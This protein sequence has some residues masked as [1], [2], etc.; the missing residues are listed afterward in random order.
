MQVGVEDL[1]TLVPTKIIHEQMQ[2]A[3][4]RI[5]LH[6]FQLILFNSKRKQVLMLAEHL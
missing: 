4:L 3:T 2:V 5:W 1:A 6:W